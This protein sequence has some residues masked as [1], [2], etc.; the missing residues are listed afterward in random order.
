MRQKKNNHSYPFE[1][2]GSGQSKLKI[3][4]LLF[5]YCTSDLDSNVLELATF[6][7][8]PFNNW[9]TWFDSILDIQGYGQIL[10]LYFISHVLVVGLTLLSVLIGVVHLTNNYKL[11]S[12][13]Q[14]FIK[15]VLQAV[16]LKTTLCDPKKGKSVD[17]R[18]WEADTK[19]SLAE[20]DRA[21]LCKKIHDQLDL[22]AKNSPDGSVPFDRSI[23]ADHCPSREFLDQFTY[24]EIKVEKIKL[25]KRL[26]ELEKLQNSQESQEPM[27]AVLNYVHELVN[28]ILR[29]L[30]DLYLWVDSILA[31][32]EEF[33]RIWLFYFTL[34][35]YEMG[36]ILGIILLTVILFLED[37]QKGKSR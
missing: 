12:T 25:T 30:I 28:F 22:L 32:V 6:V 5:D 14:S 10:Y 26:T 37:P 17:I 36:S 11:K 34:Y 15:Q 21:E 18:W 7:L 8:K 16:P 9:Y 20:L 27:N 4:E 2:Q 3:T 23:L 1:L 33:I 31:V 19:E 29:S 24:E 35:P 13:E